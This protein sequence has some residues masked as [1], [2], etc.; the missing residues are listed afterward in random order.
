M[1]NADATRIRVEVVVAWPELQVLI[2]LDLPNGA[3]LADA[4]AA[5]GLE[6]RYPELEVHPDRL[7]VFAEKRTPDH[8]L[9]EGDRVEIYRPLKMDPKEARR[10]AVE[11]R[12][13]QKAGPAPD[14]QPGSSG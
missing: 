3:T 6:A 7:G 8:V 2:P 12:R 5:S 9:G 13:R 11:A 10:Q 14:G 1:D 4:I